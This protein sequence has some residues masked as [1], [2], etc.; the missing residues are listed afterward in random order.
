M[1]AARPLAPLFIRGTPGVLDIGLRSAFVKIEYV[2]CP[3]C[4]QA[5]GLFVASGQLT[6]DKLPD[7]FEAKCP[8]CEKT[9]LVPKASIGAAEVVKPANTN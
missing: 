9:S 2:I 7:P 1:K 6:S 3:A 4:G 8:H 5:A